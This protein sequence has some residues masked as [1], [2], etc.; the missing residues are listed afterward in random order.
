[1]RTG[2]SMQQRC[3]MLAS[4]QQAHEVPRVQPLLVKALQPMQRNYCKP[5]EIHLNI[6]IYA[7]YSTTVCH[8]DA[9]AAAAAA[10]SPTAL[11]SHDKAPNAIISDTHRIYHSAWTSVLH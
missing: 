8:K 6:R 3:S 4:G 10:A 1:M 9:A 2:G 7:C 11:I 5:A